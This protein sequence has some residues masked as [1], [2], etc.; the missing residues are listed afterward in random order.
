MSCAIPSSVLRLPVVLERCWESDSW[1]RDTIDV[2][3]TL[4]RPIQFEDFG[5]DSST[6]EGE[7]DKF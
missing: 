5:K 4:F 7:D 3:V 6:L 1:L 2:K